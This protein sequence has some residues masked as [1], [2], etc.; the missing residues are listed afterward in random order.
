MRTA[1][2]E[3]H[4]ISKDNQGTDGLKPGLLHRTLLLLLYYYQR[5]VATSQFEHGRFPRTN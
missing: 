3:H 5:T 4:L 1:F 2:L